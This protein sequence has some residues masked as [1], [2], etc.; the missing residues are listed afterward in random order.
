MPTPVD[1]QFILDAS[2]SMVDMLGAETQME[3]AKKSLKQ[4]LMS[5]PSGTPVSLCVYAHRVPKADKAASCKDV[6]VMVPFQS[7]DFASISAKVDAI[8]PNGYTP[9]AYSLQECTKAFLGKEA[10]HVIILLTDGEETCGG[11]PVAEA[12]SLLAQGF[13]VTIHTIGFRVD[14]K[15]RAQLSS[16]SQATGG[17]YFDA[18]DAASLT[19]N[20]QQATQKALVIKKPEQ[21]ARGQEIRGGNQFQDA[22]P[23]KSDIE[24]RLDHHQRAKQYDYFY[25]DL[26]RGQT[27]DVAIASQDKGVRINDKG[28]A[29]ENDWVGD[30][31]AAFRVMD[32]EFKEID[33]K[34]ITGRSSKA[35]STI[36]AVKDGRYYI[37]IGAE[38]AMHKNSPFQIKISS[39]SDANSD[40]DAGE[41][42]MN[43]LEIQPMEYP[44]NWMMGSRDKDFFKISAKAGQS[45]NFVVTPQT[46]NPELSIT[47]YDRDRVQMASQKA[48]NRGAIVR[49]ENV[50]VKADGPIYIY[51]RDADIYSYKEPNAYS[52]G[53]QVSNAPV[54]PTA[55]T[56]EQPA[57]PSAIPPPATP[58]PAT[59]SPTTDPRVQ[60]FQQLMQQQMPQQQIPPAAVV[61]KVTTHAVTKVAGGLTR[62]ILYVVFGL[63]S[64]AVVIGVLLT[65]LLKKKKP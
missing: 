62:L 12:K 21:A 20:L 45:Y 18:K 19:A 9:I 15:T 61:Q 34:Y 2:G 30:S 26:K 22:V 48:A 28:E 56:A 5:I 36:T 23:L 64:V 31:R 25:V 51:V 42:I 29:I 8:R 14:E 65:L 3:V 32:P 38:Y 6:E 7:L 27:M 35:A 46:M 43:A 44:T 54:Q 16:I 40:R 57:P 1:I 41:D 60:A 55:P 59:P 33:S 13:K 39:H 50:Q 37:L 58:P 17:S 53:I 10:Q 24:Y 4:T 47:I 63:V 49:F 11:D 52:L